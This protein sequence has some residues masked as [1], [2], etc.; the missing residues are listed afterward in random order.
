MWHGL[1]DLYMNKIEEILNTPDDADI[2][3]FV[4]VDSRYPDNI[5]GKTN[6]F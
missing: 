5:K 4:E 6:N 2:G 3:Y 1:P